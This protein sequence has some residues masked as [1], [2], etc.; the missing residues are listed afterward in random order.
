MKVTSQYADGVTR[1]QVSGE[2]DMS[3]A[4]ELHDHVAAAL[5]GTDPQGWPVVTAGAAELNRVVNNLLT[6]ALRYT[7]ANGVVRIEA[8]RDG[9]DVWFAVS[10]SCGGIPDDD[11]PRVFDVA[12]RGT[13]ARTPDAAGGGGLGLAIVRG[14]VEAHGGRV[15]VGK[16]SGGCRFEVRLPAR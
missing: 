11:L 13:R 15:R 10:D 4:P 1:L 7:P 2:L 14:L 9:R 3:T 16:V 8:G 6:N 12:F 5:A